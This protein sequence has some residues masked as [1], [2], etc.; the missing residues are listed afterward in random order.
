MYACYRAP[1]ASS[2][3][4]AVIRATRQVLDRVS[5]LSPL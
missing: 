3:I 5:F 2:N 1:E 4:N